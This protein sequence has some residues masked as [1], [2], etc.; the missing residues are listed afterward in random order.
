M[1]LYFACSQDINPVQDSQMKYIFILGRQPEISLAELGQ[2][3]SG[4]EQDEEHNVAFADD[5][6]RTNPRNLPKSPEQLFLDRLGGTVRFGERIRTVGS[7]SEM[8]EV[9]LDHIQKHCTADRILFGMTGFGVS[10]GDIRRIGGALKEILQSQQRKVRFENAD[11]KPLSSGRIFDSNLVRK[12]IEFLVYHRANQWHLYCTVATQNIRN[13]TLRDRQKPFRDARMGMLPP[14]LAQIMLNCAHIP[15]EGLVL[16]PFCGS[17]TIAA[18]A[19][20]MG[21]MSWNSD[22]DSRRVAGARENFEFL[23]SKFRFDPQRGYF[24]QG[25]ASHISLPSEQSTIVT[26]G[27]LGEVF[28]T[29]PT[30]A[31]LERNRKEIITLL[32]RCLAHWQESSVERIVCCIPRWFLS[33]KSIGI[34]DEVVAF[35]QAKTLWNED[36]LSAKRLVYRRDDSV[37]G[38]EI[39]CLKRTR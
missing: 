21:Y 32:N 24:S 38:R 9:C 12:G 17:G 36:F 37:V 14:K 35:A 28:C 19:A 29:E 25:D 18:E 30:P 3:C 26:E 39:L 22:L 5:F 8:L 23:A 7:P 15:E 11:G 1:S 31:E 13:Y 2:F 33:Q 10:S 6:P 20:L 16:D 34:A 4:V 27:F